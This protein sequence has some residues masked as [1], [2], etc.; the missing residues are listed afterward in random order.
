MKG[1]SFLLCPYKMSYFLFGLD[2]LKTGFNR[3]IMLSKLLE[4]NLSL[5]NRFFLLR[6]KGNFLIWP[7]TPKSFKHPYIV[8]KIEFLGWEFFLIYNLD[9]IPHR[10]KPGFQSF[11][12]NRVIARKVAAKKVERTI[13]ISCNA[14]SCL[15]TC[16]QTVCVIALAIGEKKYFGKR[17][18]HQE[19]IVPRQRKRLI[20]K[21]ERRDR[22][23]AHT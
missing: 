16:P 1:T 15:L 7:L 6:F 13:H 22:V 2:W 18:Y 20:K 4:K 19:L 11:K 5:K 23:K 12:H 8:V 14:W 10:L 3:S 17:I 9:N 21:P